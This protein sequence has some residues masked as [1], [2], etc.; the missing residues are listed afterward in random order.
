MKIVYIQQA[1]N[2]EIDDVREVTEMQA[3]VLIQ[4][5]YAKKYAEPTVK[6]QTENVK[7]A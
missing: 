1:W 5:G 6:K 2:A 7:K 4:M 3:N